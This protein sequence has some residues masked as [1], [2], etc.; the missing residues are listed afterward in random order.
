[1]FASEH[2]GVEPDVM[3]LAKT[4]SGGLVPIGAF[5][6]TSDIWDE[7][8]GTFDTYNAHS[9]TFGGNNLAAAAGLAAIQV[10]RDEGLVDNASTL[11]TYFY[12]RLEELAR[13]HRVVRE[14]RGIG[15]M[16]GVEFKDF[17]RGVFESPAARE[18]FSYSSRE[19]AGKLAGMSASIVANV[20]VMAELLNRYSLITHFTLHRGLTMRVQPPLNVTRDQVDYFLESWA[21]PEAGRRFGMCELDSEAGLAENAENHGLVRHDVDSGRRRRGERSISI[22]ERRASAVETAMTKA[23]SAGSGRSRRASWLS[24]GSGR[25]VN[26]SIDFPCC[27]ASTSGGRAH[28]TNTTVTW[29]GELRIVCFIDKSRHPAA[30]PL[31]GRP[32]RH[33]RPLGDVLPGTTFGETTF[34]VF[35]EN[36]TV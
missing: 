8:Y 1:M 29:A 34:Q 26:L 9:S 3:T 33:G 22:Q 32:P 35:A 10:I 13:R 14:V 21:V 24:T 12:A 2:S 19:M 27:C 15:L 28:R 6:T 25:Y 5:V 4:L 23:H 17:F 7:A 11:G 16:I 20:F 30:S 31:S 18:F 36:G